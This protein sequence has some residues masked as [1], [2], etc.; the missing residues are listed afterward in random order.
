[1]GLNDIQLNKET[2]L[3]FLKLFKKLSVLKN[4]K[5][6]LALLVPLIIV[7]VALLLFVPTTLLSGRLRAEIKTKSVDMSTKIDAQI[8]QVAQV[9]E[10]EAMGSY[11]KAYAQDA[12]AMDALMLQTTQRELLNYR[13]FPPEDPC[14]FSP[15]LFEPFHKAF[16]AGVDALLRSLHAG[17][18]PTDTEV[19]AALD[20]AAT[21]KGQRRQRP[22]TT[23]RSNLRIN[24]LALSEPDR[25]VFAKV[26]EDKAKTAAVYANPVDLAGYLYWSDWKFENWDKAVKDCWY[27]QMA[28]WVLDDVTTTVRQMNQGS[29]S[30]VRS[31]VKRIVSVQFT[32][33]KSSRSTI[34]VRGRRVLGPKDK[35]TPTYAASVK[36][37]L[38]GTP[39]TGRFCNE[40]FDVMQFDVQVIV[41]TADL[42]RFMQELC[43]AKPHKFRGWRGDQPEQTFQHNQISIL[44]SEVTSFDRE[45]PEH[46]SYQY[47]PEEVV[48]V[49]LLCEYLINKAAFDIKL[50]S[51]GK[52][53]DKD[54]GKDKEET[55][56]VPKV[57]QQDIE[58]AKAPK[59]RR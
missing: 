40:T 25:R 58:D 59:G 26:C 48:S 17:T 28:F 8:K 19:F 53:K 13:L 49:D 21:Y 39:C 38:T 4:L 44:E 2:L 55:T 22:A 50:P 35:Q 10:A 51:V 18:P 20:S 14:D 42:M 15:L 56:L 29:D 31:P 6:N 32:Q 3:S 34:G 24:P 37:A 54:K 11:M 45:T 30:V 27:W 16:V 41:K 23:G 57:V 12:N 52:D 36:T 47:G 5:N 7:V 33:T 9:A 43:R 1:M 46:S